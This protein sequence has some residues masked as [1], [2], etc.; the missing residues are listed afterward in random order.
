MRYFA[1]RC[2]AVLWSIV[3]MKRHQNSITLWSTTSTIVDSLV[4]S[5]HK[6]SRERIGKG[7]CKIVCM[8][9]L[10]REENAVAP[11]RKS[12]ILAFE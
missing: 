7:R 11:Q 3:V 8:Y 9:I 4:S 6:S 10:G 5:V 1:V 2:I 12:H